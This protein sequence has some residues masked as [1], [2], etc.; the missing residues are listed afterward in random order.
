MSQSNHPRLVFDA[1]VLVSAALFPRTVP[2]QALDRA[3]DVGT[4]LI[5]STT[6]TELQG[7]LRRSKFDRYA[8]V[9]KRETFLQSLLSTTELI[10]ITESI[11][12]CRDPKDN[13]YLE[14]AIS[15]KAAII[16]TGDQ[17]LL[18]LNPFR[19][20]SIV[21]AQVFLEMLL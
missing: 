4:L 14:L 19:G 10:E 3:Q 20:V 2:R 9:E 1:N 16:V 6:F 18:V 21:T 13:Q 8:S 11:D 17:D 15:G 5:S 7:V 12:A